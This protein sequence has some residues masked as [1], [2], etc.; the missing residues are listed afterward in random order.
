MKNVFLGALAGC[1]LTCF[2]GSEDPALQTDPLAL[3]RMAATERA[4]AAATAEIGV[5]DGFLTFFSDDS[6][7]IAAGKDGASATVSPAK[8]GLRAQA[9]P[10]LPLLTRLMWEPFTGHVSV[11]GTL[12]WLTGGYANLTLATRE[13]AGKGAYFSVWKHQPDGTWRVWLDEGISLPNLW[14][15]AAPFRVAPEPDAGTEG[16]PNETL[17]AVERAVASGG[18]QW[19]ARL[20]ALIRLHRDG[21]MPLVDRNA[22]IDWSAATWQSVRYTVLR[23]LVADSGDLGIALGG[24]DATTPAAAAEHGTW[25]RVWKCDV[26]GRFRIVFETS[27]AAR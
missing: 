3:Q 2:A 21:R 20:S 9:Q 22:V 14:N 4:F 7:S 18:S 10:K 1:A 6:V 19:R 11:D 17:E 16:N 15:D 23:Q 13:L 25:I 5:R 27:K 24:Y 12:G 8:T 26:T